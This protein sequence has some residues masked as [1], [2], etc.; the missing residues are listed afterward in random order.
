[1]AIWFLVRGLWVCFW[2]L[3]VDGETEVEAVNGYS[4][5]SYFSMKLP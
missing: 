5:G 4:T 3:V 1:M 2:V